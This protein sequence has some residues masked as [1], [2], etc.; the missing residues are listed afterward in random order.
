[1]KRDNI[2]ISLIVVVAMFI[3]GGGIFA[4]QQR[5][6]NRL[7]Q[8]QYEDLREE[9]VQLAS[10]RDSLQAVNN[11]LQEELEVRLVNIESLR[12]QKEEFENLISR[13]TGS[14][15]GSSSGFSE[16]ERSIRILTPNGGE[17]LCIDEEFEIRWEDSNIEKVQITLKNGGFG[18]RLAEFYSSTGNYL[19]KVGRLTSGRLIDPD[20]GYF[21]TITSYDGGFGIFDESDR[22][23][24]I[25]QCI[26]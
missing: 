12:V 21:L 20:E 14:M 23:F 19:W 3:I 13:M 17:N 1:V 2:V 8:Q 9:T 7:L 11:E 5:Q 24:I 22:T 26:G 10:N 15:K 18:Y 6:E 25:T 4:Q 16:K